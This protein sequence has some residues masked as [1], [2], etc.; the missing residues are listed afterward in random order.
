MKYLSTLLTVSLLTFTF[1]LVGCSDGPAEDAGEK[2]DDVIT[3]AENKAEDLCEQAKEK[4]D[5]EDK[6]C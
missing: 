4:L 3:D 2:V 5:T 1:A 6:D